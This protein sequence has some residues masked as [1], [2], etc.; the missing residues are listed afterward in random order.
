VLRSGV[1]GSLQPLASGDDENARR[2]NERVELW[3]L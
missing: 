3:L 1:L 2:R